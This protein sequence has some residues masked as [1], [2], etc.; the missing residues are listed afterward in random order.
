MQTISTSYFYFYAI[1]EF[2]V[3]KHIHPLRGQNNRLS[4]INQESHWILLFILHFIPQTGQLISTWARMTVHEPLI[5]DV[6]E[7]QVQKQW[8]Q[9]WACGPHNFPVQKSL[10]VLISRAS[11]SIPLVKG[12]Y[13]RF[14]K[15]LLSNQATESHLI[16]SYCRL[17]K[18]C[19]MS[20]LLKN[21]PGDAED[22]QNC[23]RNAKNL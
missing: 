17:T 21:T 11:Q 23:T 9:H 2:N 12:G 22:S 19:V 4:D 1:P 18:Q 15:A 7:L 5:E 3:I 13:E 14:H 20:L 8:S 10:K 16:C 6:R